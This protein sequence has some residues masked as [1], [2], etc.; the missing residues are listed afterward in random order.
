MGFVNTIC[1]VSRWKSRRIDGPKIAAITIIPK[2]VNWKKICMVAYGPLSRILP[3]PT[4]P[5][6]SAATERKATRNHIRK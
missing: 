4:G 6:S 3:A 5:K 1:H 2:A